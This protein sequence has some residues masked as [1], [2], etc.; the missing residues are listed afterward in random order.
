MK[1][2]GLLDGDSRQLGAIGRVGAVRTKEEEAVQIGRN[3]LGARRALHGARND[4]KSDPRPSQ[5]LQRLL[6]T[7]EQSVLR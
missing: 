5:S 3:Q 6:H 1:A 7:R 4:A 2:S